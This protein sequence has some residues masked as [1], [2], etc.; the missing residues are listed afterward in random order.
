MQVTQ[1]RSTARIRPEYHPKNCANFTTGNVVDY[2]IHFE[3]FNPARNTIS[4]LIC[5]S[6]ESIN[7]IGYEGIRARPIAVS[8]E[9]RTESRSREEAKVR[10]GVW[11]AA[12]VAR[13][14]AFMKQRSSLVEENVTVVPHPSHILSQT[15]FPLIDVECGMWTLFLARVTSSSALPKGFR[16]PMSNI[17]IFESVPLGNTVDMVQTYRLVK[18]LR[19]LRDWVDGD[20]RKWWDV[21]LGIADVD[22]SGA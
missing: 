1:S 17:R 11:V 3:P 8:I 12:Q 15:V 18:S 7:H 16:K 14:E 4:S 10:L 21:V 22:A 2:V 20:F 6:T 13:I 9:T 5:W 19:V